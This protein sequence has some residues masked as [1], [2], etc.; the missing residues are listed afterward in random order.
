MW[1]S[2]TSGQQK[3]ILEGIL[4][5]SGRRRGD[6][7]SSTAGKSYNFQIGK[8]QKLSLA[9]SVHTYKHKHKPLDSRLGNEKHPKT[10]VH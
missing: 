3:E 10:V 1:L 9:S 8:V 4:P 6:V 7:K 2:G 5:H